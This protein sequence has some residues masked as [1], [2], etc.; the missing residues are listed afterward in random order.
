MWLINIYIVIFYGLLKE[1]V[2]QG[3]GSGLNLPSHFAYNYFLFCQM[4]G[5]LLPNA[6]NRVAK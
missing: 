6:Y 5:I 1:S 3:G 4:S 2:N